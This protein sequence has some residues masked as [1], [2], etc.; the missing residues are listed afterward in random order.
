MECI[1][2]WS[3]I[4]I[5]PSASA[6][7]L[8]MKKPPTAFAAAA[9]GFARATAR[10]VDRYGPL[11]SRECYRLVMV[12]RIGALLVPDLGRSE[13]AERVQDVRE[14]VELVVHPRRGRRA[15]GALR[16]PA[17]DR[18]HPIAHD[19]RSHDGLVDEV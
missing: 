4:V 6:S 7:T 16:K 5:G 10:F 13:L 11:R 1:P 19:R 9:R 3:Q 12:S 17:D 2:F 14:R 18:L 15:G 8:A